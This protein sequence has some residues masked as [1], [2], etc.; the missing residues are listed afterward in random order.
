M[1]S[2]VPAPPSGGVPAV[3]GVV[4]VHTNRSDGTGSIDDV[5]RAAAT[6]GLKFVIVTDHGDA[7]RAPDLPDYRD[8][9]LYI[10]AVEIST[11][12]GHL[13]LA[14]Q[15]WTSRRHDVVCGWYP[16]FRSLGDPAQLMIVRRLAG[17][18]ARVTDLVSG[19]GLAQSTVSKHLACLRDCG[20]VQSRPQGRA[21]PSQGPRA[22]TD[23]R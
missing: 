13:V 2:Y 23:Q 6:A 19:L 12:D 5:I 17:G 15:G 10:D 9:V 3:R 21:T 4:H 22:P 11:R 20:L 1:E 7:T 8:G 18:P 16:L 14:V